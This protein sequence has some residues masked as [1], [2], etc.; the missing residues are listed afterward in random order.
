MHFISTK[1]S[2]DFEWRMVIDFWG[3]IRAMRKQNENFSFGEL[4]CRSMDETE[5]DAKW[6]VIKTQHH[7][8][9]AVS[10]HLWFILAEKWP[11]FDLISGY[12]EPNKFKTWFPVW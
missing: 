7:V 11:I 6:K 3:S 2:A 4:K 12:L 1:K 10:Y 5:H 9:E 8:Q